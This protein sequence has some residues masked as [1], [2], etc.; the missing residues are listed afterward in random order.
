MCNS[1]TSR[2]IK[3]KEAS[4]LLNTRKLREI[5]IFFTVSDMQ[6]RQ[7]LALSKPG[8]T[9]SACGTFT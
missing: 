3:E 6:L 7:P 8:F 9:Y 2:F 5:M 4:G 1:K